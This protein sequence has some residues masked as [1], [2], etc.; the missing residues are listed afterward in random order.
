MNLIE[1][2]RIELSFVSICKS[3][4]KPQTL[5]T[6]DTSVIKL[7]LLGYWDNMQLS[8]ILLCFPY[9]YDTSSTKSWEILQVSTRVN[10]IFVKIDRTLPFRTDAL[11][12]KKGWKFIVNRL[13]QDGTKWLLRRLQSWDYGDWPGVCDTS[14][15]WR[16][17]ALS[18]FAKQTHM[19]GGYW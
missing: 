12:L 3:L 5:V 10:N 15:G 1:C 13:R 18:G 9:L 2:L 17:V 19:G 14:A 8:E 7:R 11:A 16:A 6:A 4:N